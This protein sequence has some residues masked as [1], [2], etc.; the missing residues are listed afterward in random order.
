M[1]KDA[2]F[3]GAHDGFDYCCVSIWRWVPVALGRYSCTICVHMWAEELPSSSRSFLSFVLLMRDSVFGAVEPRDLLGFGVPLRE[4]LRTQEQQRK[5]QEKQ[6]PHR[7]RGTLGEANAEHE[8]QPCGQV[9]EQQ[10]QQEGEAPSFV[11][12]VA[13]VGAGVAGL[14][15]AAYLR[16][17]GA[18]VVVFEGRHRV[19]GR[20]FSSVMPERVLP[21]GRK[22][23]RKCSSCLPSGCGLSYFWDLLGLKG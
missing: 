10:Q 16:R 9:P 12:D 7:E 21:D 13:V 14:A 23:E 11:V 8:R 18:S 20:T 15:A 22:V 5:K 3:I 1:S 19:G 6:Q 2:R 4:V 17:C